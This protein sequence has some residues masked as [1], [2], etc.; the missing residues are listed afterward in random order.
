M[1]E[2]L[3]L[4][5]IGAGAAGLACAIE[6]K[7][8]SLKFCVIEKG[9]V[10]DSI[11]RFPVNMKFFTTGDLLEIGEIPLTALSSK[12][13]RSEVLSY[14]R[15]VALHYDLPIRDYEKVLSVIGSD[16]DFQI[17][18]KDRFEVDHEICCRKVIVATGYFD[19][20]NMM[21]IP[22]EN[23][24]KVHH[25]YKEAHP[26]FGKRVAVIGGKNSA[27]ETALDLYRKH[28]DVTLIYRGAVLGKHIKYWILPDIENRIN[29]GEIKAFLS[30]EVVEIRRREVVLQTQEK[31]VTLPNDF[32][33]AMTGYHPDF[34]FLKKMGV[35]LESGTS[36]PLHNPETL[37]TN[38]KGIYIAGAVVAGRMTN[39]IFIE[40]GRFHG[41]QI[42][43]HWSQ[44][45]ETR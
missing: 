11:Y 5:I 20:P 27:V 45:Y 32:V 6:A 12:P 16:G 9:T 4:V 36:I 2:K 23:M 10:V 29:N 13:R 15:R 38:V 33:L 31:I 21:K 17:F 25:Y 34:D 26:F 14:Y 37:E 39:K 35:Q 19:H 8:R 24:D 22:G 28:V 42:F 3:D 7:R 40:N 30:T 44:N 43:R 1:S 18:S 41:E